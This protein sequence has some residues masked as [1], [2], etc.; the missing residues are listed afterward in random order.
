MKHLLHLYLA[1]ST[2]KTIDKAKY[3]CIFGFISFFIKNI[4]I[5]FIERNQKI[6]P[7]SLNTYIICPKYFHA[8]VRFN[9]QKHVVGVEAFLDHLQS[10]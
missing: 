2:F 1:L 8:D 5:N 3:N 9:K 6:E 7:Y 10:K 4:I